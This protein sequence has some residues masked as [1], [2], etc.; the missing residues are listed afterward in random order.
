MDTLIQMLL[1][2]LAISTL[3]NVIFTTAF[4]TSTL[5]EFSKKPGQIILLG[6]FIIDFAT[7]ASVISYLCESFMIINSTLARFMPL[8]YILSLGLVYILTLIVIRLV[9]RTAFQKVKRFIHLSAFNCATLSALFMN[10][11]NSG[12]LLERVGYAIAVGLG[13]MIAAYVLY[14]NYQKLTSEKV[15]LSFKGFPIYALYIGIVAMIVYAVNN[16]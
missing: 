6:V 14:A 2:I 11:L 4:G 1:S 12:G 7:L 13:F 16:R 10:T 9:S 3:E 5:I 8:V 15:P